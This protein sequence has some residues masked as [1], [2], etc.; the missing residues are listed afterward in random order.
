MNQVVDKQRV[1]GAGC[2]T[3]DGPVLPPQQ[4]LC[5]GKRTATS[6]SQGVLPWLL[7]SWLLSDVHNARAALATLRWWQ[8]RTMT[9]HKGRNAR[10]PL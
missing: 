1:L 7:E 9:Y 8:L 3:A 6:P 4:R 5:L 10:Q 2:P